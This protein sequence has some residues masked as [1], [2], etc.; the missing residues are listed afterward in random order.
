[1]V[2]LWITAAVMAACTLS[3]WLHA[4]R[5]RRLAYLAFGPAGRPRAWVAAAA[6]L[7]V[8]AAGAVCWGLVVLLATDRTPW[9]PGDLSP[10]KALSF[11]HLM[12][13]LDVSPSMQLADAGPSGAQRRAQRAQ[14]VVHSILD[15]IRSRAERAS[16]SSP[17]TPRPGRS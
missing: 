10:D 14:D 12:I 2:T 7:R 15:R 9:N 1:M 16:A 4:R 11:R 5:L 13:A 8:L 6:P 17:S 3:G